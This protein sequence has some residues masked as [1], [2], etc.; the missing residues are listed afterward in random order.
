MTFGDEVVTSDTYPVLDSDKDVI[1]DLV[2]L[3]IVF[4]DEHIVFF[5][6]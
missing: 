6:E 3:L 1:L 2:E 4:T 5:W